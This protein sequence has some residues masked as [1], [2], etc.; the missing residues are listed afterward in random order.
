G[1]VSALVHFEQGIPV[2]A[3]TPSMSST[4]AQSLIPLC[5]S[6]DG[7]YMFVADVDEVGGGNGAVIGRVDPVALIN[8][9]MRGPLR[10]DAVQ[11]TLD[12]LGQ[13]LLRIHPRAN[14]D[15][16]RFTPQEREV[17]AWLEEVPATV[18]ELCSRP[19]VNGHLVRRTLYV[20]TITR[21]LSPVPGQRAVS[22]TIE[23]PMPPP[24][25]RNTSMSSKPPAMPPPLPRAA[26]SAPPP[27]Q[28]ISDVPPPP[29][30]AGSEAVTRPLSLAPRSQATLLEAAPRNAD[31]VPSG[32][33]HV[34][35][36]EGGP[37][38]VLPTSTRPPATSIPPRSSIPVSA[39]ARR[40]RQVEADARFK[41]A[42][43]LLKRSDYPG[44]LHA[45]HQALRADSSA[46]NEALYGWLLY[47]SGGDAARVHPRAFRHLEQA[48][49]RDPECVDAHYYLGVMQKRVGNEQEAYVHF[50]RVLRV[51][52]DHPEAARE[53]RLWEMRKRTQSSQGLMAKLFRK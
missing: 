11:R 41:E 24:I 15:R 4:L 38:D 31:S 16:Y 33:Y 20:L 23:R 12:E 26:L 28:L 18:A 32:R 10:E 9:A 25:P 44:A 21:G 7:E 14:L 35:Y 22:G 17:A 48:L 1:S 52:P 50:K 30:A 53:T 40:E 36:P 47:L 19:D 5:A 37:T 13:R 2:A 6:A 3:R 51:R 46:M 8:A 45:A 49:Q 39:D 42:Q 34:R 27:L 43:R 29:S